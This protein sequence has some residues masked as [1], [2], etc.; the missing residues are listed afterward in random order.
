MRANDDPGVDAT[1]EIEDA[2]VGHWSHFGRW[3]HGALV[4][5]GGTLRYETPIPHLPYNGLLRTEI[6]ALNLRG[7]VKILRPREPRPGIRQRPATASRTAV[8]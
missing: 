4:E 7:I 8:A 5:D 3:P 1:R 2:L 6:A